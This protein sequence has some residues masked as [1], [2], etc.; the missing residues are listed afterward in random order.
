MKRLAMM[1]FVSLFAGS[2]LATYSTDGGV[3]SRGYVAPS[4][5]IAF[6]LKDGFPN[7]LQSDHCLATMVGRVYG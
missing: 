5:A 2:A 3:I 1:L 4:G 7:V 6:Q